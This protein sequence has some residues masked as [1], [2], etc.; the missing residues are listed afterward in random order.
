MAVKKDHDFAHDLLLGP[1]GR[2]TAGPY[3]ADALDLAQAVG[4]RLDDVE[5]LVAEDAHQLFSVDRAN[6]ANHAGCEIF[7][8]AV[9]R[10]RRRCTQEAGLELLAV[11]TVIHPF[12]RR[13]DPFPGRNCRRVADHGHE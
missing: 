11:G 10:A 7:L 1:G 9:D 3:W 12:A 5:Y 13:R 8:D 2:D 4:L 6:A